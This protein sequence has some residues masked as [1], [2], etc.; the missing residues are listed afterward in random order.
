MRFA[1][2]VV[3][4][5]DRI[6]GSS[7]WRVVRSSRPVGLAR[8]PIRVA[9]LRGA[10]HPVCARGARNDAWHWVPSTA[11][12]G[13]AA[14]APR[15]TPV[16]QLVLSADVVAPASRAQHGPRWHD[17]LLAVAPE[18]DQELAPQRA[19]PNPPQAGSAGPQ[20]P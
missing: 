19:N 4:S 14:P 18:R 3:P 8:A 6:L 10:P 9:L 15:R 11:S 7:S 1:E 12:G 5:P 20:P 13:R 16:N 17:P 2:A